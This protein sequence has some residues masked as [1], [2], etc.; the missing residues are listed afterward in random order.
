VRHAEVGIR[1]TLR[2]YRLLEGGLERARPDDAPPPRIVRAIR[3]E[4]YVPA[5]ISGVY[6]P[7]ADP[8]QQVSAGELVG[9]LYDFD[10]AASRPLEV[11][12]PRDGWLLVVPFA[13]QVEKGQTVIVVAEDADYG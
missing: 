2:H 7:L 12:A 1:N 9:R 6:E 11:R 5:P 8:G 3:L 13:A 4:D 10:Y